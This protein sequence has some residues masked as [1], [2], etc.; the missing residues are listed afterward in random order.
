MSNKTKG[1]ILISPVAIL[2]FMTAAIEEF[3]KLKGDR[4]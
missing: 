3:M 1:Y 2:F 4:K